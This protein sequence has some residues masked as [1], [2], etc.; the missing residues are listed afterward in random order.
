[1]SRL[2]RAALALVVF[3]GLSTQLAHAQDTVPTNLVVWLK[4]GAIVRGE[5]VELVPG[6]LVRVRL[7]DGE[8]RTYSWRDVR[9]TEVEHAPAVAPSKPKERGREPEVEGPKTQ[10]RLT[11]RAG[12]IEATLE[13]AESGPPAIA[14]GSDFG[15]WKRVCTAPCDVRVDANEDYRVAGDGISPSSRFRLTPG[16]DYHLAANTG[17]ARARLL[18]QILFG[19]ALACGG[20]ALTTYAVSHAGDDQ[21]RDNTLTYAVLGVGAVAL[22]VAIPLWLSSGTSVQSENGESIAR[23]GSLR[24]ASLTSRGVRW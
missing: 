14:F 19:S 15:P 21:P 17:S 22:A 2:S 11:L 5:L 12:D 18:S 7:A 1:M 6:E 16:A 9:D 13:Q 20:L 24:L 10:V 3:T 8:V 4:S 23:Q